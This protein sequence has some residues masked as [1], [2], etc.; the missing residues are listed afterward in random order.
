MALR[1]RK[2][3]DRLSASQKLEP[4]IAYAAPELVSQL[5]TAML[6]ALFTLSATLSL[7][8]GTSTPPRV[9]SAVFRVPVSPVSVDAVLPAA[10]PSMVIVEEDA[11]A[12]AAKVFARVDAAAQAA[13]AE[14]GQFAL[15]IPGGSIL[16]MLAGTKPA[17]AAQTTIAY[18]NHKVRRAL[19]PPREP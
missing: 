3:E 6:A 18:V 12:V 4:R 19:R 15:A 17:W 1:C 2:G 16:K 10:V 5:P 9:R 8:P 11:K 13:I 14:R 7:L